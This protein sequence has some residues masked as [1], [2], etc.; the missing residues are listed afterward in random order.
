MLTAASDVSF[1][2]N[3]GEYFG[4]VGE[5][6][7]GKSTV[8]KSILGGLDSNGHIESGTIKYRGEEIQDYSEKELNEK[9]RWNEIS[10]IPQ[11]SM[12]SL[13]PLERVSDQAIEIGKIHTDLSEEVILDRFREMF[14]V[15][16]LQQSRISD[17]PH[18]FSGGMQQR[19]LIAMALFLDPSLLIADEPTTALDVIMQDQIFKY[20]A[21]IKETTDTSMMLITHD[22]SLVFES[23]DS[24]AV[25]HG[26]QITET[27]PVTDVYN[28]PR[29]P[30]AFLLQEAFPDVRYPDKDLGIIDG[31]P[32]QYIGEVKECT[33]VDRCPFATEGCRQDAPPLQLTD[34]DG[35][36]RVACIHS[37][38]AYER[39]QKQ[40]SQMNQQL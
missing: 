6:G 22:I 2:V 8:V 31:T 37:D 29:H 40:K 15:V 11:G 39:Y 16:G 14:D 18:Q 27:G 20:L 36:H 21:Q 34:E 4:I 26:G 7:C 12:N 35:D 33:F 24:I 19:A 13:D 23:C 25:M 5:S 1:T 30:Y 17:Y 9:I 32:P 3:E 10:W 38:E 28:N